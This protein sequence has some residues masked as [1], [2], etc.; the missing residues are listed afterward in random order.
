LKEG[1]VVLMD[2]G[3]SVEGYQSDI[4]RTFVFG[5]ATDRQRQIWDLERKSQDAGFAAA[6]VGAPCEVV[7]ARGAEGHH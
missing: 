2:G 5:K 4:T 1:D 6:K 7:D 3:C